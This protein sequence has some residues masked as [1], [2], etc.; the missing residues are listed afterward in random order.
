MA[1]I[2]LAFDTYRIHHYSSNNIYGGTAIILCYNGSSYKGSL[3]FYKEGVTIP[4]GKYSST[5]GYIYLRFSE[6]RFNEII[7]TLREEKPLSIGFNEVRSSGWITTSHE[8][9]G[10]EESFDAD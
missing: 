6:N 10:E 8:P 2:N 5:G 9:V 3:Y 7:T 4:A 1:N